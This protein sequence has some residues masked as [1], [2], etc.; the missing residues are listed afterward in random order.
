M[1][2]LPNQLVPN[3][4]RAYGRDTRGELGEWRGVSRFS[5]PR[6]VIGGEES[7]DGYDVIKRNFLA[8]NSEMKF[9]STLEDTCSA[10]IVEALSSR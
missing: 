8:V 6:L 4:N 2:W 5:K 10:A 9:Y 7:F 1:F 3:C